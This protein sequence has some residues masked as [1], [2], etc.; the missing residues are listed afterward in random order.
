MRHK[1]GDIM[2]N[3]H[4]DFSEVFDVTYSDENYITKETFHHKE[5]GLSF[6]Y[7]FVLEE[8]EDTCGY[9]LFY[10]LIM[11]ISPKS[12]CKAMKDKLLEYIDCEEL[13]AVDLNYMDAKDNMIGTINIMQMGCNYADEATIKEVRDSAASVLETIV[14]LR[15]FYLDK[16]Q[17]RIGTI[18]WD[19][20]KEA[21]GKIK[22][23]YDLDML[24]KRAKQG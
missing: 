6:D 3:N 9:P 11:V 2:T 5:R 1:F 7:K 10:S 8:M 16:L 22:D 19:I 4:K 17:N 13:S 24:M 12:M 21:K 20:V 15:G 23:A 18:G 14:A